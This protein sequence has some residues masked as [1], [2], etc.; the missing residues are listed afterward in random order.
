[1]NRLIVQIKKFSRI[2]DSLIAENKLLK[3]DFEEFE[4]T[5]LK[6]PEEGEVVQGTGG[7]RKIRLKASS[8]GKRGG[9]R[10]WYCDIPEKEKLFLIAIYP[11]NEKENLSKEEVKILKSL[12]EV[13]REE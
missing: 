1:M 11:K 6:N 12:V 10:V 8:K 9:F 13:L 5:L 7:L 4:R 3:E 2:L